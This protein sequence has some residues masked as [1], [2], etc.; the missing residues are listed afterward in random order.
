MRTAQ[1][2][3]LFPLDDRLRAAYA[4]GG[5]DAMRRRKLWW[6]VA[7]LALAMLTAAVFVAWPRPDRITLEN[8]YRIQKGMSRDEVAAI[9][10][11]PGDHST[12]PVCSGGPD[13]AVR[14]RFYSDPDP[15][16]SRDSWVGDSGCI[17][18]L[19]DA[20]R[21][22]RLL[23]FAP[24]AGPQQNP[25]ENLLWRAKRQWRKWFPE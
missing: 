13:T 6:V 14:R 1:P 11:P 2:A 5:E 9:L 25:L 24:V 12:R 22:P 15:E 17:I 16:E 8:F 3:T 23:V 7:G 10:G 21:G 20:D 19:S 4:G 18:V